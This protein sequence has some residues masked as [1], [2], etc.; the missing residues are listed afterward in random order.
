MTLAASAPTSARR[1]ATLLLLLMLPLLSSTAAADTPFFATPQPLSKGCAAV[2]VSQCGAGA[3]NGGCLACGSGA[4]NCAKCCPGC[5]RVEKLPYA[6]CA[7]KKPPTPFPPPGG[8][9]WQ[10]YRV[11]GM[12]VISVTGGADKDQYDKVVVMLHGGGGSGENWI[13]VYTQG[14]LGDISGIKY[15]FPTS[16]ISSHVWYKSYKNGCG[17]KDDCGYNISS[18]EE[19]ATRIAAL[20]EKER[21]AAQIGG[22]AKQI[23]LAG[24]SEGAQMTSYMQIAKL[25]YALGGAAIM[26]GYPL[27]P[28][29]DMPGADPAAAKRNASYV[30]QDMN[31]FLYHGDAD[32]IFPVG[33]TE[34]AY[35]GVFAALGVEST[36]T[37]NHTEP[38]MSHTL[39][40]KEFVSLVGWIH[41]GKHAK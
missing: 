9:S 2:P 23:F 40:E 33:E 10:R 35:S 8:D 32:P 1:P 39:T 21:Q 6:F 38:G 34:L 5:T 3:T 27:P 37:F 20:L 41:G 4:Y 16:A 11:A 13:G 12:D 36:L 22:N 24:F 19:S 18:I 31:F 7:C 26:D 14:W 28:L 29:C 17:L 25:E 30:G 15:V